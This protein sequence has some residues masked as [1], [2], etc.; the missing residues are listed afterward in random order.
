M[1]DDPA[2]AFDKLADDIRRTQDEL[3]AADR[4]RSDQAKATRPKPDDPPAADPEAPETP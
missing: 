2:D 4:L 1:P 3:D